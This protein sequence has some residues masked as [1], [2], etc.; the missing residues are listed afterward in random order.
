MNHP[1]GKKNYKTLAIVGNGFD[2]AHGFHTDY[3]SFVA[4]TAD[5]SLDRFRALCENGVDTTTWYLFEENI[6]RL[7][8]ELFMASMAEDADY[9]EVRGKIAELRETFQQIHPLL[10]QYLRRETA[11]KPVRRLAPVKKYLGRKTKVL[12]FNYTDIA[13]AYTGDVFHVHGSLKENDILLGYDARME[14][15]LAGYEDIFWSKDI[16]REALSFRRYL[17]GECGLEE[18][19]EEYR[20]LISSLESYQNWGNSGRGIDEDV[21]MMIPKFSQVDGFMKRHS[22]APSDVDFSKIRT[23]V[24]L[25]HGIEADRAFLTQLLRR[26]R[27]LKKVVIFRYEGESD[28]SFEGKAAFFRPWCKRISTAWYA[29]PPVRGRRGA[30]G[31]KSCKI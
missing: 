20:T 27:H 1:T 6:G 29:A 10:L 23:I 15:C 8:S 28:G 25:G 16:R 31:K 19:S 4:H 9:D 7:S 5:P 22:G 17:K 30:G 2:L 26:C 14:P 21:K 3:K 12:T 24:V 11:R 13:Q 18:G